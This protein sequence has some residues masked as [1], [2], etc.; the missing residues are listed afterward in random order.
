VVDAPRGQEAE[1]IARYATIWHADVIVLTRHPRSAM[2]R[3]LSGSVPDQVM[4]KASCP[5]LAVHPK[6]K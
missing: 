5:V 3:L 1:A 2:G 6:L 4:R